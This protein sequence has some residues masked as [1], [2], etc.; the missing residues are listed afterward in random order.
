MVRVDSTGEVV[1]MVE[2]MVRVVKVVRVNVRMVVRVTVV[3]STQKPSSP[4]TSCN[5]IHNR[6]NIRIFQQY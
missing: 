4:Q 3:T 1:R 5:T 2:M 6:M